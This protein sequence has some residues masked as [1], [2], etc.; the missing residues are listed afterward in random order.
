MCDFSKIDVLIELEGEF[1][2]KTPDVS[3]TERNIKTKCDFLH[4]T[5]T[6]PF[7]FFQMI[8]LHYLVKN[9]FFVD[10]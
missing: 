2:K 5:L 6:N 3:T 4:K 8:P 9:K 7:G 10:P 1:D